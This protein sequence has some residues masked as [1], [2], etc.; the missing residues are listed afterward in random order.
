MTHSERNT[1]IKSLIADHTRRVT[2]SKAAAR[3]SLIASG[4]YTQTGELHASYGGPDVEV[5]KKG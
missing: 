5:R 2:V 4:I 3:E 1:A